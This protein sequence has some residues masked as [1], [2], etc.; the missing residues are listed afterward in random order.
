MP[1]IPEH[2]TICSIKNEPSIN[3]NEI[4]DTL[5][6]IKLEDI[7]QKIENQEN[8]LPKFEDEKAYKSWKKSI[9]MVLSN[10]SSH[11]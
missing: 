2:S 4:G 10:I 3:N 1:E 5:T 6:S 8:M 11:K 7:Q 9:S